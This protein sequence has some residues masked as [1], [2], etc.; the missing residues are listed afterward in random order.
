MALLRQAS[1]ALS[2]RDLEPMLSAAGAALPD[3]LTPAGLDYSAGQLALR[4]VRL[5]PAQT[6][7]VAGKL[8]AQG[9]AAQIDGERL[10]VRSG[11]TR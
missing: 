9:Y 4:G 8:S 6:E 11:G 10:I 3:G 7:L 1:G 5:N 2:T